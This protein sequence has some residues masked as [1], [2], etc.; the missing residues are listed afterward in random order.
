MHI[1]VPRIA[2][3]WIAKSSDSRTCIACLLP[4][5]V[6]AVD[7]AS[8]LV[9]RAGSEESEAF[10]LSVL[11]SVIFD[12]YV[13]KWVEQ[14][15][16]FELLKPAP[17]PRVSTLDKRASRLIENSGRLAASDDRF[18]TWAK[19]LGVKSGSVKSDAERDLL[20]AENDALVAHVY[21]LTRTQIEHVF[22]TF[23]RG[24]DYSSRLAQ[25]L[26]FYDKLPT[27]KA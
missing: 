25:V 27:V 12:W 23:H 17:I 7:S 2:I 4:P 10:L 15:F 13:R 18:G 22:K 3:R 6:G 20:I 9:R 14:N 21:G 16:T 24:W 5:S 8:V 1:D 19:A 11:S 26:A